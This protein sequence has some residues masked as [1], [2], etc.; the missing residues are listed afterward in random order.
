[1]RAI[2]RIFLSFCSLLL[3]VAI[4]SSWLGSM[5]SWLF[6]FKLTM[7]FA[8]P[9]WLMNLPLLFLLSRARHLEVWIVP[10]LGAFI[11]PLCLTL[12][13][14]IVVLKG[15][16]WASLLKSDPEGY[17]LEPTLIF[18]SLIGLGTNTF[19]TVALILRKRLKASR[20]PHNN[21]PDADSPAR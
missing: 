16:D 5:G 6:I 17:G 4:F 19:Y 7:F 20:A 13:F 3:A 1:M 21:D 14:G 10:A 15:S 12:W 11:G 2:A 18:A 9:V 8:L